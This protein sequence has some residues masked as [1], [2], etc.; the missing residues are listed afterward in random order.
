MKTWFS[1]RA[2]GAQHS[3]LCLLPHAHLFFL[4]PYWHQQQP[5]P[6]PQTQPQPTI[7]NNKQ[8]ATTASA[9]QRPNS[10]SVVTVSLRLLLELGHGTVAWTMASLATLVQSQGYPAN[11]SLA[12]GSTT[13]HCFDCEKRLLQG[14]RTWKASSPPSIV[15]LPCLHTVLVLLQI[16]VFDLSKHHICALA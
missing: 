9:N 6:K 2:E 1:G 12:A 3:S 14:L 13:G 8:A 15:K 5:K 11:R 4:T 10:F 16:L 7:R